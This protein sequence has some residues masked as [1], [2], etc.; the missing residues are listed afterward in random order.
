MQTTMTERETFQRQMSLAAVKT[1]TLDMHSFLSQSQHHHAMWIVP[2]SALQ[3]AEIYSKQDAQQFHS[4][5]KFGNFCSLENKKGC[6][7]AD[8]T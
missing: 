2:L 8:A 1:T 4:N 5:T 3:A 6:G 7:A